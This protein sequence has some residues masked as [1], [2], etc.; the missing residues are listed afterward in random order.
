LKSSLGPLAALPI[1][2]LDF[3]IKADDSVTARLYEQVIANGKAVVALTMKG[4]TPM[5][6]RVAGDIR[7]VGYEDVEALFPLARKSFSGYRLLQEYF[8]LPQRFHFFRLTGLTA[9]MRQAIDV[10]DIVI[11]LDRPDPALE[12]RIDESQFRLHCTPAINLFPCSLDRL[13]IDAGKTEQRLI[14]DRNRPLD[15]EIYRVQSVRGL[16][17]G[18]PTPVEVAPIYGLTHLGGADPQRPFFVIERQAASPLRPEGIR[19]PRYAGTECFISVRGLGRGDSGPRIT[20]L[21][22]D[23][24]CTN[25]DLPML[26]DPT[27]TSND[28]TLEG[29]AP[30][31]AVRA[32]VKPTVPKLSPVFADS[33]DRS[34][35]AWRLVSHLAL[36]QLSLSGSDDG[37]GLLREMLSLYIALDDKVHEQQ[38]NGIQSVEYRT[39]VH[40]L[41]GEG[42]IVYGRGMTIT[43]TLDDTAFEG[44]GILPLA[45][46]LERFFARYVSL[47]SFAR[48]TL[49]SARRGQIKTWPARSG[50]GMLL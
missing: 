17:P 9:A 42:P 22:I 1:E 38:I 2:Q 35:T 23:A 16:E 18:K 25:R 39:G 28:F 11:L 34:Q 27:G 20:E 48:T 10:L 29:A 24:L 32:I 3:F 15:F 50:S 14:V 5:P 45:S 33:R 37:P 7:A 44:T 40:R 43:L 26:L 41:P 19:R 47:N 4:S 31:T 8:A 13:R 36:N 6:M 30:V 46:V 21:D 12:G 49:S